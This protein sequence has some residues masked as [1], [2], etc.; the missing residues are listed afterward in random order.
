MQLFKK[1]PEQKSQLQKD[2]E[3]KSRLE[4]LGYFVKKFL[5]RPETS[6]MIFLIV[7]NPNSPDICGIKLPKGKVVDFKFLEYVNEEFG[8]QTISITDDSCVFIQFP[9]F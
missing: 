8:V 5:D 1:K 3:G 9:H 4:Q 6:D 2:L 7:S